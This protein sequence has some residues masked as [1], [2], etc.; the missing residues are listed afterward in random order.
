MIYKY[1]PIML[2]IIDKLND[3][4]DDLN[5]WADEHMGNVGFGTL[6]FFALLGVAFYGIGTLNKKDR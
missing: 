2:N 5:K 1:Y 3:W 4:N 6:I